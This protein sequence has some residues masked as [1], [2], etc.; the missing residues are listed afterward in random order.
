M[1]VSKRVFGWMMIISSIGLFF[2]AGSM[3]GERPGNEGGILF[4]A[5]GGV[6]T[7]IWGVKSLRDWYLS[8]GR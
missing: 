8:Q 6:G 5:L 3:V 2:T 1:P 7:L 4:I